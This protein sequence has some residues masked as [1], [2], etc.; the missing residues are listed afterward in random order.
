[1]TTESEQRAE[2]ARQLKANPLFTEIFDNV[3]EAI[4]GQIE[5]APFDAP[6]LRNELAL[7]LA[8]LSGVRSQVQDH[9]DT[10]QL[11]ADQE[12]KA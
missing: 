3:K 5:S 10:A 1:M 4:I 2:Q 11:N 7:S 9:I 8:M 12:N 6:E